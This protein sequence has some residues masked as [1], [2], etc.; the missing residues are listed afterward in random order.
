MDSASRS[1]VDHE[2]LLDSSTCDDT[3]GPFGPS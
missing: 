3:L 1:L 2:G